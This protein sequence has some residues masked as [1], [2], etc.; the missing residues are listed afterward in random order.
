M[1]A[2]PLKK[3]NIFELQ[4]DRAIW[5]VQFAPISGLFLLSFFLSLG[6]DVVLFKVDSVN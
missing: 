2:D 6:S 5:P 3:V 4:A 1:K